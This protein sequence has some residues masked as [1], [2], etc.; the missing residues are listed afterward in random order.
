MDIDAST[1]VTKKDTNS[2]KEVQYKCMVFVVKEEED[3][4]ITSKEDSHIVNI[5]KDDNNNNKNTDKNG[6]NNNDKNDNHMNNDHNNGG[7]LIPE[8]VFINFNNPQQGNGHG[9]MEE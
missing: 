5:D 7:I 1:V 3:S 9:S 8:F 4:M 2:N 6:K